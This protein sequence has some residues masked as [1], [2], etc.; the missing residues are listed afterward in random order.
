MQ[1][2][3]P[4]PLYISY[5]RIIPGIINHK[6]FHTKHVLAFEIYFYFFTLFYKFIM[7]LFILF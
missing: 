5:N 3:A 1:G 4:S 7:C 2:G 6:K